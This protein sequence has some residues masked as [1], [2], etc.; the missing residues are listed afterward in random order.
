MNRKKQIDHICKQIEAKNSSYLDF[1][2]FSPFTHKKHI[3]K[4]APYLASQNNNKRSFIFL[5]DLRQ[6]ENDIF[7]Y[8]KQFEAQIW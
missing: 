5:N 7:Q 4:P 1:A 3:A 6:R 8:K 2:G